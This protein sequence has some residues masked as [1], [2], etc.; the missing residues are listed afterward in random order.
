MPRK[1]IPF[2]AVKKQKAIIVDSMHPNGL[3]LSHWRGAR[4]PDDLRGDTSADI[5][6]NALHQNVAGLEEEAVTANHFDIDGFV[7]VWALLNQ[8]VA[9]QNEQLLRQMALI[10]DFRELDLQVP[11]A[12]KALKLVCWINAKEKELFYPPFGAEEQEENEVMASV[13]KFN[14][15]LQEF[16]AVLNDTDAFKSV[17]EQEYKEVMAGYKLIN[18]PEVSIQKYPEIGLVIINLPEPV[19]Y[20]A[21]F[22]K[23]R[24]FD[25]VLAIYNGQRYELEY[26]YTTWIDL[27]SRS[28]LPRLPLKPLIKQLNNVEKSGYSWTGEHIT[29]TGPI[30]RLAGNTLNK[31]ERY[32]NPTERP[33]YASTITPDNLKSIIT[34]YFQISY[35]DIQ[36]KKYWNWEEI[37]AF[38]RE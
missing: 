9:L 29:D 38:S 26:K 13:P 19:H 1:Y 8:E 35:S 4:T 12:D 28:T 3:V 5:V 21:L 30:L 10:G 27:A 14:Y 11:E 15:F 37:K 31:R 7:G 17:W 6:F 23:T 24:G 18:Q 34:Q 2:T 32:A 33:I 25:M 20:Y 36:P 16:A 22:S